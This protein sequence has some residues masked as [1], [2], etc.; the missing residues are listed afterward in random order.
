LKHI[1]ANSIQ[2]YFVKKWALICTSMPFLFGAGIISAS[3][4]PNRT[5]CDLNCATFTASA[6]VASGDDSQPSHAEQSFSGVIVSLNGARFILRDDDA[7][8]WY[9][10][11]D[12]NAVK[13]YLGK[14][15]VI[16]GTLDGRSDMI[17][18]EK[19]SGA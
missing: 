2:E 1:P 16:T 18:V 13:P 14:K 8:T 10:L 7:D 19:I 17:H 3:I 15:V 6:H 11:D 5:N 4:N 9:H 12:Q